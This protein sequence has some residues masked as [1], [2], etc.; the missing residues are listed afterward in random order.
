MMVVQES[1]QSAKLLCPPQSTGKG[2]AFNYILTTD[3]T[4]CRWTSVSLCFWPPQCLTNRA[5]NGGAYRR[6][7]RLYTGPTASFLWRWPNYCHSGMLTDTRGCRAD[8]SPDM[9]LLSPPT[10]YPTDSSTIPQITESITASGPA[11]VE[12]TTPCSPH[13]P[14]LEIS[15]SV[16]NQPPLWM[17]SDRVDLTKHEVIWVITGVADTCG[18]L[19]RIPSA[20]LSSLELQRTD[21]CTVQQHLTP[22][23]S[24]DTALLCSSGSPPNLQKTAQQYGD[25]TTQVLESQL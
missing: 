8:T 23:V 19:Q 9:G 10:V 4:T 11:A 24:Q 18:A 12:G 21:L 6:K 14:V 15:F 13:R 1:G 20:C 7:G 17:V 3:G 22:R 2:G 25:K 16:Y 5:V